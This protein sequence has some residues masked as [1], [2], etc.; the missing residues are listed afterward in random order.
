MKKAGQAAGDAV[1]KKNKRKR[2]WK[3]AAMGIFYTLAAALAVVVM[4]HHNPLADSAAK[5]ALP[6]PQADL[7]AG[8]ERF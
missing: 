3:K 2:I 7:E 5:G 4:S 6:K 8:E 1:L